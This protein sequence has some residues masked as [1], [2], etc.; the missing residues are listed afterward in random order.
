MAASAQKEV[1][2]RTIVS[3]KAVSKAFGKIQALKGVDLELQTGKVLGL[4]GPNSQGY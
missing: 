3:V 2:N 4:L 1:T